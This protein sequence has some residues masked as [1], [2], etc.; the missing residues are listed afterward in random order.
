MNFLI[1]DLRY[2][3]RQLLKT[4]GLAL[5]ATSTLA[6]GIGANTA[7]FTI[8]EDVLLRPLPYPHSERLIIAAPKADKP[9]FGSTS[10]LNYQDIR[11][12]SSMLDAVGSYSEDVSV[13][14]TAAGSINVAAPRVTPNLFSVMGVN[15]SWDEPSEK[16]R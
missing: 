14:E 5:L 1:S 4:P 13:V 10:W 3:L 11:N 9:D 16:K 7:I 8:I 6:L 15:Q 2:A 12:Q